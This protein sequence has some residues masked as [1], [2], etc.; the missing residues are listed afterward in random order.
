M[1]Y[2]MYGGIKIKKKLFNYL[3]IPNLL[4]IFALLENN[5]FND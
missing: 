5:K 3:V 2:I 4:Y 1:L